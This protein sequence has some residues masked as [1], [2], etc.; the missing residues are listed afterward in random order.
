MKQPKLLDMRVQQVRHRIAWWEVDAFL[1][2]NRRDIRYLTGFVGD[3][4]WALITARS[5]KVIV[6]SDS[7][8]TEQIQRQAP[9]ATARIRKGS[10]TDELARL[11]AK[12]DIGRLAVQAGHVT[13]SLRKALLKKMRASQL[14]PVDDGLLKQRAVK[15]S[16]EVAAIQ[17]AIR[18]QQQAFRTTVSQIRPG[19]TEMQVAARL[20]YEMRCLGADGCSFPS[21]VAIDANASLPHAIPSD[22]K[23]TKSSVILIDWGAPVGGVLFRP[24]ARCRHGP[25]P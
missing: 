21:I 13:L 11:M 18:I 14:V 19:M 23:V 2:T 8:F 4:S 12:R 22:K 3:D 15:D 9:Q 1:V 6:I 25:S 10:M 16:T 20:E 7:R 5:N 17:R 24:D